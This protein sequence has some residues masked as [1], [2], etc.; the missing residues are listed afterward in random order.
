M[1]AK[2]KVTKIKTTTKTNPDKS[3]EAAN[4]LL[5]DIEKSIVIFQ[6]Q[7]KTLS[8]LRKTIVQLSNGNMKNLLNEPLTKKETENLIQQI[9]Y[10][11]QKLNKN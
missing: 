4:S 10:T 7:L 1:A 8:K 3:K 2:K 9:E 6:L 11:F 5:I